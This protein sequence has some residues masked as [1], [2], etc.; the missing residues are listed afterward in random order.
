VSGGIPPVLKHNVSLLSELLQM[1]ETESAIVAFTMLLHAE[2]AIDSCCDMLGLNISANSV[3]RLLSTILHLDDRAVQL[4]LMDGA[5]LSRTELVTLDYFGEG[6]LRSRIDPISRTFAKEMFTRYACA[7]DMVSDIVRPCGQV[8]VKAEDLVHVNDRVQ[9]FSAYLKHAINTKMHGSNILIYGV[10]GTGKTQFARY[11]SKQLQCELLEIGVCDSRGN[12][13]APHVRFRYYKLGQGLVAKTSSVILFDE[14]EEV[15]SATMTMAYTSSENKL[16]HKSWV[17]NLLETN[18]SPA[19]WIANAID[20]IDPAFI[21]R[22]DLVMEMPIPP[23]TQRRQMF[24]S[25]SDGMVSGKLLDQI[26]ESSVCTPAMLAQTSRVLKVVSK[27]MPTEQID[28]LTTHLVNDRLFAQGFRPIRVSAVGAKVLDF[29]PMVVNA[30]TPLM[31]LHDGLRDNKRGK[32]CIYGPPGSGKT[33]FGVWLAKSLGLPS[34]CYKASDL[35][36]AH[37]GESEKAVAKA[38]ARAA[39]ESAVLQIDEVDSFLQ[40]R[41][42]AK[43]SWEVSIVNE[44]LTQIDDFQG[45]FIASTNRFADLDS[46]VFRRFDLSLKFDYLTADGIRSLFNRTC[47]LLGVPAGTQYEL[48]LLGRRSKLTPGDF[49]QILRQATFRK[50]RTALDL[51]G[52]MLAA[53]SQSP[54]AQSAQIG[55][56]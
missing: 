50:P 20:D 43:Q 36:G 42:T 27:G 22:F 8:V 41:S 25:M 37:V 46:A 17:N 9:W 30:T 11:L 33:G 34:H 48:D 39:T 45:I 51:V 54:G 40:E 23:A 29:D 10:P 5:L 26:V 56:L 28:V 31:D 16:G 18:S 53:K 47:S 52:L 19:I 3:P 49:A 24:H 1:N 7:M 12:A 32:V 13:I 21:R 4:A 38:F 35:L 14:C 55:F 2:T 44:M 15:L 6:N